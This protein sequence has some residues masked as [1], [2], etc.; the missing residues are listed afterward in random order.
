MVG[1]VAQ[2][3]VPRVF[4]VRVVLEIFPSVLHCP[5]DEGRSRRWVERVSE[6]FRLKLLLKNFLV[7]INGFYLS[8]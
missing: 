1:F 5:R 8:H 4:F 3:L 6:K 2:S 7:E